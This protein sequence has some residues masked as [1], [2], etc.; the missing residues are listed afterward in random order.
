MNSVYGFREED[1][2]GDDA[3]NR[4]TVQKDHRALN[5]LKRNVDELKLELERYRRES[6]TFGGEIRALKINDEEMK[7]VLVANN[8]FDSDNIIVVE[9][10]SDM[11]FTCRA[12]YS[13]IVSPFLFPDK[14]KITKLKGDLFHF[15]ECTTVAHNSKDKVINVRRDSRI[16]ISILLRVSVEAGVSSDG[17]YLTHDVI[18]YLAKNHDSDLENAILKGAFIILDPIPPH[19]S[20]QDN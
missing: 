16:R 3:I 15:G 20:T 1:D 14:I 11:I 4:E 19:N 18:F 7:A 2:D 6:Q 13:H 10:T 8:L 17:F 9:I 5:R 12:P